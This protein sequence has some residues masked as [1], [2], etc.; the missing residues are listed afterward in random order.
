M[1]K[2]YASI[3]F[4]PAVQAEQDRIGS[5]SRFAEM[6]ASGRD[7]SC[8][9]DPERDFLATR[10]S[11]YLSSVGATGWPYIQHR[12]G[13]PGFLRVSPDGTALAFADLAGNRQ[14]VSIGNLAGDERV[15]LFCMDYAGQHRLKLLGHA[16]ALPPAEAPAWAQNLPTPPRGRVEHVL[17]VQLAGWEWNCSQH[18]P[19]LIPLAEIEAGVRQLA[20]RVAALEAENAALRGG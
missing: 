2:G 15:A 3:A 8:L 4:T 16:R 14:H 13:P 20:E 6:A 12:G 11:F 1:G 10:E 5:R 9:G 18:I 17:L 7:D 19:R